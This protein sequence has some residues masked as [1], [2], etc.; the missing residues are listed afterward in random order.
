MGE[1]NA[2]WNRN[3]DNFY[4]L[5]KMK[6]MLQHAA[7]GRCRPLD[8]TD[9]STMASTPKRLCLDQNTLEKRE[10]GHVE[11]RIC[12]MDTSLDETDANG[13]TTRVAAIATPSPDEILIQMVQ[14]GCHSH[15]D[16][17]KFCISS[18]IPLSRMLRLDLMRSS[19]STKR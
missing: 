1:T 2:L 19:N 5:V 14:S 16:V 8:D 4:V 10:D 11:S 15:E 6:V 3:G 18:G 17:V 12:R 9:A 13:T 7:L